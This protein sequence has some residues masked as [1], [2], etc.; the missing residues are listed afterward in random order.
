MLSLLPAGFAAPP[1]HPWGRL[2]GWHSA[3]AVQP[4]ADAASM[5][6][7]APQNEVLRPTFALGNE[8]AEQIAERLSI[9]PQRLRG[10]NGWHEPF[11]PAAGKR[12]LYT[13]PQNVPAGEVSLRAMDASGGTS[14]DYQAVVDMLSCQGVPA[15]SLERLNLTRI[16]HDSDGGYL[17]SSLLFSSSLKTARDWG[18]KPL[19]YSFGIN[20]EYSFENVLADEHG[21]EVHGYDPTV[22]DSDDKR[23]HFH[24]LGLSNATY[25]MEGVG[26][27]TDFP[28]I[29]RNT[30]GEGRRVAILKIDIEGSE[31]GGLGSMTDE[32]LDSIDQIAIEWHW[33]SADCSDR[34]PVAF[35][36]NVS[37]VEGCQGGID[38]ASSREVVR[39]VTEKFALV[40]THVN[41]CSPMQLVKAGGE[42]EDVHFP[43]VW[44]ATYVNKGKALDHGVALGRPSEA[45]VTNLAGNPDERGSC[46]Y[47]RHFDFQCECP[48]SGPPAHC[49]QIHAEPPKWSLLDSLK[50]SE[51]VA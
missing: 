11:V 1:N 29:H 50:M 13:A 28:T 35:Q 51:P 23:F 12:F 32:Q 42:G 44:E 6:T 43:N 16:G 17:L 46:P 31:F 37:R 25:N 39:R 18:H 38:I 47:T 8:T 45:T 3:R 41:N 49:R 14:E 20:D 26:P 5:I 9:V 21:C 30:K 24:E 15:A 19:V 7:T 22:V 4:P 2:T 27:V 34:D 36:T 10:L 48:A 40:H 33:M